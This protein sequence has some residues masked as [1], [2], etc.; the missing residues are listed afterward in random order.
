MI[1]C[2]SCDKSFKERGPMIRHIDAVHKGLKPF[3]CK[4][5][6]K[7][8]TDATPL[9]FHV[10]TKHTEKE[11]IHCSGSDCTKVFSNKPAFEHHF[12]RSHVVKSKRSNCKYCNASIQNFSLKAHERAH[13]DIDKKVHKCSKCNKVFARSNDLRK[14]GLRHTTERIKC[15]LCDKS[16]KAEE[17]LKRHIE[18]I[19]TQK[20]IGRWKC[21]TCK[22]ECAQRV[23]MVI[24]EKKHEGLEYKCLVCGKNFMC[25]YRLA[26]H[27]KR[28]HDESETKF[29]CNVCDKKFAHK[30][31]LYNHKKIHKEVLH[32]CKFCDHSCNDLNNLKVHEKSHHQIY[33]IKCPECE[34]EFRKQANLKSHMK[35]MHRNTTLYPCFSISSAKNNC[36]TAG[37]T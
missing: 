18:N 6:D 16:Y 36:A 2:E 20:H 17:D 13:E 29:K 31:G 4:L 19:H 32:H 21:K 37:V 7:R 11:T 33:I 27:T 15:N 35:L 8:Y 5:C 22:K 30:S 23:S 3:A 1:K 24:H 34:K 25:K 28:Q 14:H 12:Y 9:R 26:Y 10:K